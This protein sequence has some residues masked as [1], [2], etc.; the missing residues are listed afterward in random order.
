MALAQTE[1]KLEGLT[2]REVVMVLL[3]VGFLLW[4]GIYPQPV[5]DLTQASMLPL[6]R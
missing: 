4:L 5:L 2:V 6:A 3:L 1:T